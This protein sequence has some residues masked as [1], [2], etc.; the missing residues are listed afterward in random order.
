MHNRKDHDLARISVL[1]SSATAAYPRPARSQPQSCSRDAGRA[2]QELTGPLRDGVS[3]HLDPCPRDLSD[4]S[5]SPL[6]V[7]E[8]LPT[9]ELG[10]H[11]EGVG[12]RDGQGIADRGRP[13]QI[14]SERGLGPGRQTA[15]LG[16]PRCR[17]PG[18]RYG[19][20]RPDGAGPPA[21]YRSS[22]RGTMQELSQRGQVPALSGAVVV[23]VS[24]NWMRLK[25]QEVR[26]SF[27]PGSNAYHRPLRDVTLSP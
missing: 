3:Q 10:Q 1:A 4:T 18:L 25:T 24:K 15:G 2:L 9:G 22:F 17:S 8:I 14:C 16:Q 27:Q 11:R 19:C 23:V 5:P 26:E 20:P 21:R 6:F 13:Q 12:R 7:P